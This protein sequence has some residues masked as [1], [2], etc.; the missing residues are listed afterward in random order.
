MIRVRRLREILDSKIDWDYPIS[1]KKA[2]LVGVLVLMGVLGTGNWWFSNHARSS[3][4]YYDYRI[5][6]IKENIANKGSDPNLALELGMTYY[7][8]GETDKGLELV[9]ELYLQDPENK[10]VMLDYGQM[11][12]D[13]DLFT[14]STEILEKLRKLFPGYETA[15]VN[16]ALGRNYFETQE[17]QK[18]ISMLEEGLKRDSGVASAYYYLGLSYKQ[19][20]QVDQAKVVLEKATL[21]SGSYPEA[22]RALKDLKK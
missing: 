19:V 22:Q 11:L 21:L 15:K 13:Q 20:G 9:K 14:E 1:L 5:K 7:L 16:F 18:A 10:N 2:S 17:Y 6:Q 8:K 3:A 12:S 4:S